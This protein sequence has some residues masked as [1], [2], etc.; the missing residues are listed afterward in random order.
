MKLKIPRII[1]I[2][3]LIITAITFF[4]NKEGWFGIGIAGIILLIAPT[5]HSQEMFD[6]FTE[7]F[8]KW[9]TIL[10]TA[11]YDALYWLL[12]IGAMYFYQWRL[13][14]RAVA[15]QAT[16]TIS[17]EALMQPE[18]AA[19]G[20]ASLQQ[21]TFT[22]LGGGILLIVFCF[23]VYTLSR[24]M[25][26][27]TITKQKPNKKFFLKFLG[28]NAA[29]WVIWLTLFIMIAIGMK[30]SPNQKESI[31]TMLLVAYYFTPILHTL[32]TQKH[33]IGH[34]IGNAFAWGIAKVHKFIVPYTLVFIIYLIAY[35]AFRLFENTAFIKPVAM[36]F[37]VL[38]I[39]WIR[40]Y[41]YEIIKK[42]K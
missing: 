29:W 18:T 26:W 32:F 10:T 11:L 34:S 38:F 6:L 24:G 12:V 30:T 16:T 13:T 39:S 25:I 27:T 4:A 15:L 41:L 22:M 33:L 31:V 5:K 14:A 20:V 40:T 17:K 1:G 37:V 7:S 28:L 3:L 23:I 9:K 8:Q 2:I 19:Q 36:L 42:F 21:L 35:Q